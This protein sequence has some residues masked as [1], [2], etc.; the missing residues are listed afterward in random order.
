[1]TII[2][3]SVVGV[4]VV[5]GVAIESRRRRRWLRRADALPDQL[6]KPLGPSAYRFTEHDDSLRV[7]ADRRKAEAEEMRRRAALHAAGQ[8]KPADVRRFKREA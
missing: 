2:V 5:C 6:I 3:W 1:M 4:V 8:W 7:R